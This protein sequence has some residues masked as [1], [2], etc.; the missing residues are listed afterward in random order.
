MTALALVSGGSSIERREE[1]TP[2]E[3][4]AAEIEAAQRSME[5][6][7]ER[8]DTAV[9]RFVD[10]RDTVSAD[11]RWFN[12]Y[13]ANVNIMEAALYSDIPEPEVTR[14]YDDHQDDVARV[15]AL[16]LQR[17]IKQDINDP[18]DL[19]NTAMAQAVQDRLIAGMACAWLRFTTEVEDQPR[20]AGGQLT[21]MEATTQP[22]ASGDDGTPRDPQD[23][24][25]VGSMKK[26]VDQCVEVDYVHWRDFLWPPCRTW[27]ER[28]W[29]ARRVFMTRDALTKRFGSAKAKLCALDWS[30]TKR[31]GDSTVT[32]EEGLSKEIYRKAV[33]WEIWDREKRQVHWYAP[34][35]PDNLLDTRGD[36]LGLQGF[37][38]CPKPMLANITTKSTVPRPDYYMI[39]DQYSELN[40]VNARLSKLIQAC[41]VVGVY[42]QAAAAVQ[43]LLTA[44][45]NTLIPVPNWSQFAEKQGMK[46][47]IDWLPLDQ[48]VAAMQQLYTAREAIKGQIYELTGIA[49]IV[50]G[51][52]K[53]SETLGA[54][55]I[56]A[57]FAGIRIKKL[58]QETAQ[59]ASDIL[60]IKGELSAKHY[61]PETLIRRSGIVYTDNHEWVVPA[62]TLLK[63]EQGFNWRIQVQSDSM[64]QADYEAEKDDRIKFT[65]AVTGYMAQTFPMAGQIPE[66]KPIVMG[67]LKWMIAGFKGASE[68]E[69]MID[70]QLSAMEGK[71]PPPPTPDPKLAALQ[72]KGQID[73]AKAQTD[74]QRAQQ[75]MQI[76]QQRASQDAAGKQQDLQLERER[77]QMEAQRHEQE[78]AQKAAMHQQD[79]AH[80]REKMQLEQQ[81]GIVDLQTQ[82]QQAEVDLQ[83]HQQVSAQKAQDAMVQSDINKRKG[84]Q[85]LQI[86]RESADQQAQLARQKASQPKPKPKG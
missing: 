60:R 37:E 7:Y 8:A 67:L 50:R 73:Q 36:F 24:S 5:K 25:G 47:S 33:V 71:P 85:D 21:S 22:G 9:E 54:Q 77:M 12:I 6:F 35:F 1:L 42:D 43:G 75:D 16:I 57:Q 82:Q 15:A 83:T 27:E 69:G 30:D 52:T 44:N 34:G 39:Q 84:E 48:V 53:A 14:R 68:V 55:K 63:S 65:S 32:S 80:E 10:E 51:D 3:L 13:Y 29:V 49:D 66:A 38:P 62:L 2:R 41:K 74:Q 72:M 19:F 58:Q 31:S 59:F 76:E 40:D 28:R 79:M 26:I 18:N 4:W 64:A 11:S 81:K 70:K 61:T 17:S 45:E 20:S 78:L 86:A 56:K 23:P 46:G